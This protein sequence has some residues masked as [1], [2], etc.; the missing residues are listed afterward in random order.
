MTLQQSLELAE[1]EADI[2]TERYLDAFEANEHPE[3]LDQLITEVALANNRRHDWNETKFMHSTVFVINAYGT[4]R[5][6]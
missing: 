5:L 1:L 4:F 6:N 3:I 2:A